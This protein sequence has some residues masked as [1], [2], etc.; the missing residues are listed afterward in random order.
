MTPAIREKFD[1]LL[2]RIGGL[3]SVIVAFSGGV[4]SAFVLRAAALALGAERVL[5]ITGRSPSVPAAELNGV[6]RLAA[7]I[8][9]R[10]EFLDT[11]EFDDPNYLANP[12]NRCYHCK[13]ELYTHLSRVAR[14]R[15][16]RAVLNGVNA[17]DLGDSRPGLRAAGE[18]GVC[19]P[20]VDCGITKQELREMAAA[21]GLS[22]A[23]KPASP[24]LSSRVQYGEAIT[25]EKLRRIDAAESFLRELGFRECRVRHHDNLARIEVPLRELPRLLDE[26]L[27]ATVDEKLRALGYQYVTVDLRGFRSG[28]LNEVLVRPAFLRDRA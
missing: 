26:P 10:H 11:H 8:G 22:V 14:E 18:H 15:G 7:E 28:S 17:D 2:E 16:Y 3:E 25:P 21:M 19:A 13:T 20:L 12:S 24:C 4:D 5:A 6:E 27:R 23:D 1:A 9:A